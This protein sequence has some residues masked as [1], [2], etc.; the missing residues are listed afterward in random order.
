[1]LSKEATHPGSNASF[2][3]QQQI[4]RIIPAL[5]APKLTYIPE[6]QPGD[7]LAAVKMFRTGSHHMCAGD[8]ITIT[9]QRWRI[10]VLSMNNKAA[11]RFLFSRS[12]CHGGWC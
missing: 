2:N 4:T 6:Y 7:S 3:M 10:A 9:L 5:K 11:T 12:V 1:M 8:S